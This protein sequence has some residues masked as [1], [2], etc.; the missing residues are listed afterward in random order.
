MKE[1]VE[2]SL[3]TERHV[4][5][6]DRVDSFPLWETREAKLGYFSPLATSVPVAC[7]LCEPENGQDR[8][9]RRAD[10]ERGHLLCGAKESLPSGREA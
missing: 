2:V 6:L 8:T 4:L 9:R 3:E 7:G 5:R 10:E 1:R